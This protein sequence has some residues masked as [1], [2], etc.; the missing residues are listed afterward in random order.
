V[1]I[2]FRK[3]AFISFRA[4]TLSLQAS[5]ALVLALVVNSISGLLGVMSKGI[6]LPTALPYWALAAVIGGYISA[7]YGSKR[8]TSPTIR[9]ILALV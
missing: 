6:T 9:K 1:N 2:D 5:S 8:L 4:A 3:H 7:E